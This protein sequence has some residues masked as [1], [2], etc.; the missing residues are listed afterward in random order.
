MPVNFL[1]LE[2]PPTSSS[3]LAPPPHSSARRS[4]APRR[5]WRK[6]LLV[7]A[8]F[9]VMAT[10]VVTLYGLGLLAS[11]AMTVKVAMS[12]GEAAMNSADFSTAHSAL[13][14]AAGGLGSMR[15]GLILLNYL[16]PLPWVGE[17]LTGARS[18]VDAASQTVEVLLSGVEIGEDI[19]ATL[20]GAGSLLGSTEEVRPYGQL[21]SDEKRILL[22]SLAGALPELQ[23]MQV[24]LRLAQA[25]VDRLAELELTPALAQAIQPLREIIPEL[26][27]SVEVLVPFAAIAPEYAGLNDTRQF[28]VLFLNDD[29]LRPGGG[30]IGV[31]GLMTL[32]DGD[33]QSLVTGDSYA[34]DALVQNT[35][36]RVNPPPPIVSFLGQP[37][38]WFRDAAWSPD[39]SQ[40]AKDATQLFRQ[41][42][43]WSGQPV[44]EIHGVVGITPTFIASLL[45]A[46]GPITVEGQTF[47]SEN[48]A[49]MLEY[50]VEIAFAEDGIPLD[51]RK[52]IVSVLTEQMIDRLLALPPTSWPEV[53]S[54]IH[55]AF[56]KKTFALMS[57]DADTQ[58]VLGDYGWGG[59]LNP[60]Q[61]DDVLMLVDGNLAS[62]KT[63][64]VMERHVQYAI[65]PHGQGYRATA[66][67]TY[68][69]TGGF[70][71]KTTRY[72]TYARL[73][74]PAGSQLVSSS[75]HLRDD[76][77]R[78]PELAPG[79][80]T[81]TDE[82]GMT[83][84]GA[85]IAIEPG[86][87]GTLTF[88]Y[89]L[90]A[91]V[92]AAVKRGSYRLQA[93]KQMAGGDN[94]LTLDLDF[95]TTVASAVP[96][97][98]A[99][100]FHNDTYRVTTELTTDQVF[101]VRLR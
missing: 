33:I 5:R 66:T 8:F 46:V 4:P 57:A 61:T 54:L 47:T 35:E 13:D 80:V 79:T 50:Q 96:A 31:Y 88:V 26:L 62:L 18:A 28:L 60:V 73:Y 101:T 89:D 41:E 99:Q 72:R 3:E 34:I 24:R 12:R 17:Q 82:F 94:L 87:S 11:G 93:I 29:E 48:V 64:R 76:K 32:K 51:Q 86:Q 97:E 77:T 44:P 56:D 38:W 49:D 95:G 91:S 67:I 20:S 19:F 40:T 98:N 53:F 30:F 25:D 90:P 6:V 74:V 1:P 37:V 36:Y 9:G 69:H 78:N 45:E 83:S 68:D 63:D 43:A 65:A 15:Q 70:D 85:F 27:T 52:E 42:I 84:F 75:G 100:E 92:A 14:E 16:S 71:W 7:V 39:F 81:V 59:V 22:S 10:L 23:D 2:S 58:A 21:T 55:K